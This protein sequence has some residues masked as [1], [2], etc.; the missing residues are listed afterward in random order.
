MRKFDDRN[1]R[2]GGIHDT[3]AL[4]VKSS[5][6]RGVVGDGRGVSRKEMTKGALDVRGEDML[7]C[8]YIFSKSQT[9]I[10]ASEGGWWGVA[11]E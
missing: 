10:C 4:W 6:I 8:G 11:G 9:I 5:D 2:N 3:D 1:G 7:S